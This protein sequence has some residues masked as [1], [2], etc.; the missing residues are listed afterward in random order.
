[1]P[2]QFFEKNKK[3]TEEQRKSE[4]R[5]I[6]GNPPYSVGQRSEND[7]NKNSNYE[8]LDQA[9]KK[10]YVEKSQSQLVRNAYD[11]YIRAIRWATDRVGEKGVV[12]FVTNGSFI[13]ANNYGWS[14][15]LFKKRL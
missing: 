2:H 6:V 10:T 12:A 15:G 5:V 1:M 8:R 13:E 14:E 3:Q 9:I 4:I 11:S 7:N